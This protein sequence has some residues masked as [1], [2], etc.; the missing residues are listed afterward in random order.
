M[1]DSKRLSLAA[2]ILGGVVG[3]LAG[4]WWGVGPTVGH[5]SIP[6]AVLGSVL[7][8]LSVGFAPF[9]RIMFTKEPLSRR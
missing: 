6:A 1:S 8:V 4:F 3:G 7:L 5:L 9:V 2:A